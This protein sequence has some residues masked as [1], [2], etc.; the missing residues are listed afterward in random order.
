MTA[1][2][3][4]D[5]I[6]HALA[7]AAKHHDRQVR[8]GARPPYSTQSANVAVI[9]TRYGRDDATVLAG[10][11][12]DVVQDLIRDGV[13]QAQLGERIGDKFGDDV[14]AAVLMA[15]EPRS[16]A[17]GVELTPDERRAQLL[18]GLGGANERA[19][20][21]LAANALHL[22]GTLLADIRRTME[23]TSVW[24]RLTA[25]REGTLR[26]YRRVVGRLTELGFDGGIVGELDAIVSQLETAG[27]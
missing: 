3:Y 14:L 17:S 27:R 15:V 21:V 6:N 9:L 22:A 25:G 16:D 24:S 13:T 5:R 8:R 1:P 11:L 4:S 19:R 2:G 10:I 20:W 23:A 26:W 18:A 7:F 12:Y